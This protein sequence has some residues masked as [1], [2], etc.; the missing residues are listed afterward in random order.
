MK[1]MPFI[2]TSD[3]GV[4]KILREE[5]FPELNKEGIYYVFV[6]NKDI[7]KFSNVPLNKCMFS[8]RTYL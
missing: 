7:T 4:A 5:G 8:N 3:E 2:K 6:N 1:K